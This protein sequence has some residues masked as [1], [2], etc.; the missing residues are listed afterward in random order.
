MIERPQS[1]GMNAIVADALHEDLIYRANSASL[2]F[3][4]W[5]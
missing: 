2:V 4:D 1:T 5:K 3:T